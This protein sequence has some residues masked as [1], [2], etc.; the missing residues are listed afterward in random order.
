MSE[1]RRKLSDEEALRI[2][3]RAR[4]I[5][6]R[7]GPFRAAA[8]DD[9]VTVASL[10]ASARQAGLSPAAIERAVREVDELPR[11]WWQ[12][13]T[14]RYQY[15]R[16]IPG[17]TMDFDRVYAVL[18]EWSGNAGTV[19]RLDK[20]L[21]WRESGAQNQAVGAQVTVRLEDDGIVVDVQKTHFLAAFLPVHLTAMATFMAGG[22]TAGM[23]TPLPFLIPLAVGL[24]AF[25]LRQRGITNMRERLGTLMQN[26]AATATPLQLAAGPAS[27]A[28]A[29]IRVEAAREPG[30]PIDEEFAEADETLPPTG[31]RS[32]S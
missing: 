32:T 6:G 1:E 30:A 23:H 3:H 12:R 21:V 15:R 8:H 10:D 24:V 11:T 4:E 17:V 14:A 7:G 27:V 2:V 22:M 16:R 19:S 29:R 20:T 26:I 13:A 25:P 5:D 31:K 9:G 28:A 18:M